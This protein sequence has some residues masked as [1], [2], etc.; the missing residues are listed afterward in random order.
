MNDIEQILSI[1]GYLLRAL[2]FIVLGFG[3]GRFLMDAYKKAVWQV[4]IAL[5]IGFGSLVVCVV[6]PKYGGYNW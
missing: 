6:A 2:G 3:V 4:Q 5:S 1:L